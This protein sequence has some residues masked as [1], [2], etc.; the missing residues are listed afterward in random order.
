MSGVAD[1]IRD[2]I[3]SFILAFAMESPL[4]QSPGM[5]K[6]PLLLRLGLP[7]FYSN[8]TVR[9]HRA[10]FDLYLLLKKHPYLSTN[11][12]NIFGS[13]SC[14]DLSLA[15]WK[16]VAEGKRIDRADVQA[17]L[18]KKLALRPPPTP[19]TLLLSTVY[20]F[21]QL[22]NLTT[23]KLIPTTTGPEDRYHCGEEFALPWLAIVALA[24]C[25]GAS[26][27]QMSA[28]IS[29]EDSDAPVDIFEAF[30]RFTALEK[31]TWKSDLRCTGV[32]VDGFILPRLRELEVMKADK[33]FFETLS[34]AGIVNLR[35]LSLNKGLEFTFQQFLSSH[36]PTLSRIEVPIDV[37]HAVSSRLLDLC[38]NLEFL[39]IW[40]SWVD[41]ANA[42]PDARIFLPGS[43]ALLMKHIQFD[44]DLDRHHRVAERWADV[45]HG[46]PAAMPNLEEVRLTGMHWPTT[47][48]E[49]AKSE[50][51]RAA[52]VL[53]E[54]GV[55]MV[56]GA[57]RK[58]RGRL[59]IGGS[60]QKA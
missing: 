58:W 29:A 27:R 15:D 23:L 39:R 20:V 17:T 33:S 16:L 56:D 5:K 50:W 42:V 18:I 21:A 51:V 52:V 59:K 28:R 43:P 54:S 7:H 1:D 14:Y 9:M 13:R 32:T 4:E 8:I 35:S 22:R 37:A 44:I 47:E 34:T 3:W 57:G 11:V 40:W 31:L 36:G 19:E 48:R 10:P 60:K 38:P 6:L 46:L 45:L 25:A 24:G 2:A 41:G 30:T 55:S 26:L 53:L 12:R 49:I